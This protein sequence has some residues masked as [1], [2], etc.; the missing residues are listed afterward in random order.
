MPATVRTFR[1]SDPMKAL[2]AV[3]AALGSEAVIVST[4]QIDGGLFGRNEIE[5]TAAL[6]SPAPQ[7]P[8]G[9]ADN[10]AEP[11][12]S[13]RNDGLAA[14]VVELRKSLEEARKELRVIGLRSRAEQEMEL[15]PSA[16]EL[17]SR[18]VHQGVEEP[19]AEEMV[20]Q[21]ILDGVRSRPEPLRL[22]IED[23]IASRLV[24]ARAPW[25]PDRKRCLALV[26]PTGVG[27]TTT[28]AKIA[29]R[30][31]VD[32]R[33]KV[34]LITVDTYRIGASEQ[35]ARY[36]SIMR[37][38][39]FVA[40]DKAELARA[41]ARCGDKDLIL[42]DSAGRSTSEAVA[43]QAELVRSVPGIQLG[44]VLS[45]ATGAKELAAAADR[46]KGLVPERL[47]FSKLDEAVAPGS[48]LSAAVRINRPVC[49]IADGQRVPEDIHAVTS[50]ELAGF[51][52]GAPPSGADALRRV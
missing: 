30:A 7:K 2:S 17:Y 47:I 41:I 13:G 3:K 33:M 1:A 27:K 23:L 50:A 21:V 45:A 5:V 16:A 9:E 51:V 6:Q 48:M 20:R 49:C 37:V 42:V 19:L 44:L 34:A 11:R 28:L 36:G 46:Y 25:M 39:T 31:L 4:R 24:A 22:A 32:H 26:G 52:F 38:P 35:V 12:R 8:S 29:A 15:S 18:L 14:E 43:R 40:H 10:R